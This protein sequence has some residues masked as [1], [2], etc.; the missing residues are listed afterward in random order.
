MSVYKSER[1]ISKMEFMHNAIKIRN[2]LTFRVLK[3]F[4]LKKKV[5]DKTYFI[6]TTTLTPDERNALSKALA[7]TELNISIE[8]YPAWFIDRERVY[9]LDLC[10]DMYQYITVA[11]NIYIS[12]VEEGIQRRQYQNLAITCVERLI[13]ELQYLMN[14]I[15]TVQANQLIPFIEMSQREIA[16]LKGWRKSDNKLRKEVAEKNAKQQALLQLNAQEWVKIECEKILNKN[17]SCAKS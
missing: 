15:P 2:F 17:F 5:K 4:G 9:I 14:I 10:R 7:K 11:N 8:E 3:D 6:D 16:L 1:G 12:T 13:Q